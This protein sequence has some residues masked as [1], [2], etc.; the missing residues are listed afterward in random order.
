MGLG[1]CLIALTFK[2]VPKPSPG[3][4]LSMR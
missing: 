1:A 3:L 2:P 4:E